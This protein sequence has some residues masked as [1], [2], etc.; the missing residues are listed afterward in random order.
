MKHC[1]TF[2]VF[3]GS[4]N[5]AKKAY[6]REIEEAIRDNY[7]IVS[8]NEDFDGKTCILHDEC[9]FYDTLI[10]SIPTTIIE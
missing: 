6:K 3:E 10:I 4:Y 7:Q 9:S 8:G 5:N 2:I 1:H